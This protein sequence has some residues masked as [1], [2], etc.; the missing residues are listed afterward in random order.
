MVTACREKNTTEDQLDR[1]ANASKLLQGGRIR[2]ERGTD[3]T[4]W[5]PL[6][7]DFASKQNAVSLHEREAFQGQVIT[8]GKKVIGTGKQNRSSS[9]IN[10]KCNELARI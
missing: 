4:A 2:G 3:R 5:P 8:Q 6:R 9:V 10:F 1:R 7:R